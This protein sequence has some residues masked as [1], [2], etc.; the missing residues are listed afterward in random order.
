MS[1]K[2]LDRQLAGQA[3]PIPEVQIEARDKRRAAHGSAR[4]DEGVVV[5]RALEAAQGAERLARTADKPQAR[6]QARPDEWEGVVAVE[7]DEVRAIVGQAPAAVHHDP[8]LV[9]LRAQV[10]I[11]L[12]VVG[13]VEAHVVAAQTRQ[14]VR[15]SEEPTTRKTLVG[16][17]LHGLV[18]PRGTRGIAQHGQSVVGIGRIVHV[19]D[20]AAEPAVDERRPRHQ[21]AQDLVLSARHDLVVVAALEPFLHGQHLAAQGLHRLGVRERGTW[22]GA[23]QTTL[24]AEA[25]VG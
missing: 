15:A 12:V 13:I 16:R 7:A 23:Q 5:F 20:G 1:K 10:G 11:A 9:V 6:G 3:V 18:G 8:G 24:A 14:S 25:P 2:G 17:E 4:E 19:L 22:P 21:I